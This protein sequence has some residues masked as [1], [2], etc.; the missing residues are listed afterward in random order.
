VESNPRFRFAVKLHRSF[1]HDSRGIEPGLLEDF[2]A[3]LGPLE[4]AERL[5]PIL[6]QFPWSFRESEANR[7]YLRRLADALAPRQLA[8]ELRHGGWG[9]DGG[10][11]ELGD[12]RLHVVSVDQP[13]VGDSLPPVLQ[14]DDAL[15]YLRLH[16]R[17]EKSWFAKDAGRDQRYDYRYR[18]EELRSLLAPLRTPSRAARESYVITNNHFQG[19]AVVNALQVRALLGEEEIEFPSWLEEEFPEIREWLRGS[20]ARRIDGVSAPEDRAEDPGSP[21]EDEQLDLFG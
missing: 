3:C 4:A 7:E 17:N 20:G 19:Q 16:G 13:Q 10:R 8:I 11:V 21:A 2:L 1:T 14:E 6:V 18:T 12:P 15:L 5:G 9:R